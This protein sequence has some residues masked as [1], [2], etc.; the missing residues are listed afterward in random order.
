MPEDRPF[1]LRRASRADAGRIAALHADSWRR[2]YR[3]AFSDAFLDG[4]VAA[5]RLAVWSHRLGRP[6]GTCTIVAEGASGEV[7]GFVHTVPGADPIWGALV[8][9]LHVDHSVQRAGI[10]STLMEETARWLIG[11]DPSSR[12]HLWVLEQNRAA[13]AFYLSLGGALVGS[14]PAE[15]PGGVPGRL[16]GQPIALRC[17]WAEPSRILRGCQQSAPGV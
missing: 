4:D 2:H 13:Q 7:V 16:V 9:N 1:R 10:G 11:R 6:G 17:A 3:G 14:R 8:D 15:D 5:D 12:L